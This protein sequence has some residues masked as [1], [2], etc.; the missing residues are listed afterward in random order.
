MHITAHM[1]GLTHIIQ[2]ILHYV[3]RDL[4]KYYSTYGEMK[5]EFTN[6]ILS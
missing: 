6:L 1:R 2:E 5:N 4:H 3:L